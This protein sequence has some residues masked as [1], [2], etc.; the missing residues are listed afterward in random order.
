MFLQ[1]T[2]S[3]DCDCRTHSQE[4]PLGGERSCSGTRDGGNSTDWW[5]PV[6]RVDSERV[7]HYR[8][9]AVPFVLVGADDTVV[10]IL[11]PLQ[12]G[13]VHTET[14]YE[15][16]HQANYGLGDIL[17]QYLSGEKLKGQLETEEMLRVRQ[18]PTKSSCL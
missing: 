9:N 13:G 6:C 10:K 5:S 15:K 11:D 12:A 2:S 7:L 18:N 17:G 3:E 8:A 1:I 16:F 4:V 14:T